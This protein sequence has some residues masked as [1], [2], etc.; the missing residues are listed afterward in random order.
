MENQ[1][2]KIGGEFN[3]VII[4]GLGLIL[5]TTSRG[6]FYLLRTACRGGNGFTHCIEADTFI[7]Y[8]IE[9]NSFTS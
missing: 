7:T 3:F 4:I 6:K 2:N 1:L 9:V 5:L 8:R